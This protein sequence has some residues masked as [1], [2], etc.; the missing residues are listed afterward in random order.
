MQMIP[1]DPSDGIYPTTDYV[2]AMEVS[3]AAR[4]LFLSGTMGLDTDGNAPPGLEE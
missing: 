2:H 4:F 1:R 3:G